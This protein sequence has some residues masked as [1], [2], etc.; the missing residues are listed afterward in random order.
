MSA[1][2]RYLVKAFIEELNALRVSPIASLLSGVDF[3]KVSATYPTT[4][5]ELYEYSLNGVSQA[6]I[7]IT[8]TNSSKQTFV[9]AERL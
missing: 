1:P 2:E 5:T 7:L 8:Y 6:Q 4:S 9:S 3:D